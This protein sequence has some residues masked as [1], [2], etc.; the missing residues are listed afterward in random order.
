[1]T[2]WSSA[3]IEVEVGAEGLL[4]ALRLVRWIWAAT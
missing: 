3:V 4:V 1:M 2:G